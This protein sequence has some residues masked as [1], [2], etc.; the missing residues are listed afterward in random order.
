MWLGGQHH[1][2]AALSHG[3]GRG[4]LGSGGR[5]GPRAG[6]N[7]CGGQKIYCPPP[8]F[9]PRIVHPVASRYTGQRTKPQ[10]TIK[11]LE[12]PSLSS[13]SGH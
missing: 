10:R 5:V 4:T 8:E 6:L 11:I 1:T 3:K 7:G 2:S 9:E 12:F 13:H